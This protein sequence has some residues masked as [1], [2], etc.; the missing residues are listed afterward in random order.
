MGDKTVT[1]PLIAGLVVGAAFVMLLAL[2]FKDTSPIPDPLKYRDAIIIFIPEGASDPNSGKTFTPQ[3]VRVV[4]REGET[5]G[6][7]VRWVNLD[8][9]TAMIFADNDSDPEFYEAT[10]DGVLIKP[11]ESFEFTFTKPGEFGYH[12]RPW[13]HGTI[14]VVE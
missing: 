2:T 13:Q 7:N 12:G 3:L 9:A 14:E 4:I 11:G 5:L 1:T 6:N 8:S 10:K